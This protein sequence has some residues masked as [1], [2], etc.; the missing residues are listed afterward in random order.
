MRICLFNCPLRGYIGRPSN[1]DLCVDLLTASNQAIFGRQ[2]MDHLQS[3]GF[4]MISYTVLGYSIP[5]YT[6]TSV[7]SVL[8]PFSISLSVSTFLSCFLLHKCI[9]IYIAQA[10]SHRL[11]QKSVYSLWLSLL[12]CNL[13]ICSSYFGTQYYSN[14]RRLLLLRICPAAIAY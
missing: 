5:E 7:R 2:V 11:C 3:R 1:R 6:Q 12:F 9:S 8:H 4:P 14:V 13:F 10:Q